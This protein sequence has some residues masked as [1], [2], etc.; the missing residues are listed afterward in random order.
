MT[1]AR[2]PQ[3]LAGRQAVPG[4]G[5]VQLRRRRQPAGAAAPGRPGDVIDSVPP[6]NVAALKA[7]S[8]LSCRL[9]PAWAVDLLVLQREG[10]AVRRS[11]RAAGDHLRDRPPGDRQGGHAS[12]PR[13]RAARS[14]RPACSTTRPRP[15]ARLQPGR[16]QG[17]AG[18]VEVPERVR[19][20]LLIDGGVQKWQT[21]QIIQQQLK[22]INI[23]SRSARS[24]T[25]P[26]RRRSRSST[27]SMFINNAINDISDPDEMASF[28]IDDNNGGSTSFWTSYDNPAAIKLVRQAEAELDDGQARGAV[29]ARSSR[30]SRRTRR[31]SRSTTRRTSTRHRRRSTDSR[32]TR[33]ARPAGERLA[34][35]TARPSLPRASARTRDGGCSLTRLG[36]RRRGGRD[37]PAAAR[38]SRATRRGHARQARHPGARSRQLRR[39][40]GPRRPLPSQF[41]R[42]LGARR[43]GDTGT[44]SLLP[45]A[46]DAR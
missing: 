32:S 33:A 41:G 43:T 14:S 1:L 28:Q 42:F 36:R 35:L 16:G 29:Q 18:E 15:H 39:A 26:S 24:T 3:L 44:S 7:D 11:A 6:A 8:A 45:G 19:T 13:S 21:A 30:S 10:P 46:G 23:T 40:V 22:A 37:L 20:E 38:R 5:R 17:G 2:N 31:T 27:T 25:P 4:R 34:G 9:F 12:A